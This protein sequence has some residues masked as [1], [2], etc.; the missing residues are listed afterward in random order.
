L[1]ELLLDLNQHI[2]ILIGGGGAGFEQYRNAV[3]V[4]VSTHSF[5]EWLQLYVVDRVTVQ[6]AAQ[7]SNDVYFSRELRTDGEPHY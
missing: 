5:Y 4:I 3:P 1:P 6:I 7:A 2:V